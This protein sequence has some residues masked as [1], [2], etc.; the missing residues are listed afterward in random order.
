MPMNQPPELSESLSMV[1]LLFGFQ[2]SQALFTVAELNIAT[3]LLD[4]PLSID[5]LAAATKTD[6]GA[7]RRLV[8][9]LAPV[10][11]FRQP[12]TDTVEITP[13]GATLADGPADSVR[14]AARFLMHTHYAPFGELANTV[15]TG[16]S[17]GTRYFDQPFFEWVAAD[18]R[19]VELQNGC[20]ADLT[21]ALRA[22]IFD[23]YRL[24]AGATVADIGGSDGALLSRLI[25]D[26]PDRWGIVFDV[27]EVVSAAREVLS[28]HGLSDRVEIVAGSFFEAVPTADV[29]V[30]S[31]ILHDWD[32]ASCA[33][34]LE[35]VRKA[36]TPGARLVIAEAV[37]PA[38]DGSHFAKDTDL[39]MLAIHTGRERT[40][41]EYEV[42]LATAGFSVDRIVPT[43]SVFSIIEAT[44]NQDRL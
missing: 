39:T 25:A 38:G 16:E 43:P 29:Y 35:N 4:G 44:L 17:G 37:V 23:S 40:A 32:E 24:P 31:N 26:E 21:R 30:L 42:L 34:I 20:F 27:P 28:A 36:A 8:R 15:R 5:Q 41:E 3:A 18:P 22:S 14:G 6:A 2:L 1:Q 11:V 13:F 10:G 7:L 12:D 33:R 19:L 9:S